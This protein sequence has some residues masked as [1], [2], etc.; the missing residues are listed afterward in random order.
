MDDDLQN[1]PEE[2]IKL[3][4][5]SNQGYDAVYGKY[6]D[7]KHGVIQKTLGLFYHY[8]LHRLLDIPNDLYLSNFILITSDVK[9]HIL[10]IKSS[11]SFLTALISKTTPRDKITNVDV[12]HNDRKSGE[13]NYGILKHVKLFSNL[14]IHYSSL[15]LQIMGFL[16]GIISFLSILYGLSLIIKKITNPSFGLEGW[17]SMMVA[18]TLLGGLILMSI[19]IIGEYIRRILVEITYSQPYILGE[20]E[21]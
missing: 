7:K 17:Y 6:L 2:I 9:G 14:I 18:I 12:L 19:A 8:L 21:L 13:S 15:P 3:I 1:P 16:G 5:T 20:M 11:Y 4:D 10:T